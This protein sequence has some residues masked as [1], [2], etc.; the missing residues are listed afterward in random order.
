MWLYP[1]IWIEIRITAS[2]YLCEIVQSFPKFYYKENRLMK[3]NSSFSSIS[4]IHIWRMWKM[5]LKLR[6]TSIYRQTA[7]IPFFEFISLA[8]HN[9]LFRVCVP[10]T[11]MTQCSGKHGKRS[12]LRPVNTQLAARMCSGIVC[13]FWRSRE[14][15]DI[16]V[17]SNIVNTV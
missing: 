16:K 13:S 2:P 11:C 1:S 15:A 5:Y 8:W 17:I 14:L 9:D 7:I 10:Q 12:S 3:R 6:I 4:Y